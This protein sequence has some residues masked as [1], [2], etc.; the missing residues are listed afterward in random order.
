M[1]IGKVTILLASV[2][3][4]LETSLSWSV[5]NHEDHLQEQQV[6]GAL[7]LIP[8]NVWRLT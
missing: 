4:L 8:T 1:N 7:L 3:V 2:F 5:E 6:I